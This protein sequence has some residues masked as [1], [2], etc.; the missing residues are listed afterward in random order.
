[1]EQ[2]ADGPIAHDR[3][4][5]I[6]QILDRWS[7]HVL[8]RL[9]EGPQRFNDLRRAIPG[10]AQKSLTVTLRRLERNGMVEREVLGERPIAV[11]YRLTELGKT[12]RGLVDGLLA[13]TDHHME[14]VVG[15]R[16]RFDAG[17]R[18]GDR[19]AA[20]GRG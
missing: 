8:D 18:I 9:C 19:G 1:M 20:P 5:L 15:A 4:E 6:D 10:L 14:D 7:L 11:E 16:A 3:R 12:L 13:W 2:T 17:V